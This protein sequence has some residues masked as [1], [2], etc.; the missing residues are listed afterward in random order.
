MKIPTALEL[1]SWLPAPP[2]LGAWLVLIGILGWAYSHTISRLI[3]AWW[4]QPDYGHGFF[5]PVFAVAL[6]WVRRKM[7]DPMPSGCTWWAMAF[8]GLWFVMRLASAHWAYNV[9][10]SLSILPC[11]VGLTLF[12]GGWRALQWAWPSITFLIFMI[13]LP[14]FLAVKLR[15]P[16]QQLGTSVSVFVIQTLGIRAI[17]KGEDSNVISLPGGDLGVVEACSGLRM[18]MLFFAVCVGAALIIRRPLWEKIVL[19][20][21]AIPIA[22]FANVARLT[23]TALLYEAARRFPHLIDTQTADKLFHDWAGYFMMPLAML[24][25]WGEMVLMDKLFIKAESKG[26][27]AIGGS[28]AGSMYAASKRATTS[29]NR[30]T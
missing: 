29:Q 18:L 10:D 14:G 28:L 4:E 23:V 20:A 1:K 30:E 17:V 25:L 11:L 3:L 24:V 13:P 7:V 5:V 26:P 15:Y 6:L 8:F 9:V 16:L 21:S 19:V 27:L 2:A 22:V 12:V